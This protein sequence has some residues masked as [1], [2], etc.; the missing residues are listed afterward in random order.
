VKLRTTLQGLTAI[1]AFVAWAAWYGHQK[2]CGAF[3]E[4]QTSAYVL[5]YSVGSTYSVSQANCSRGGHHGSYKYAYD[6]VMPIGTTVTAARA[7]VVAEIRMKFRDGQPGE[8]ESNWVKIRHADG[9]IAAYSHLTEH[10][11]LVKIGDQVI[12]GQPIGLSGNTGNTG[13]LPHLHFHLCPCSEPVQCGT[14]P[15]TFRN[16]DANPEGLQPGRSYRAL[17]FENTV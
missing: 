6:F 8:A 1:A 13:G 10:G 17:P 11:A 5:P 9:T 15:V 4:W 2:S 3:P 14:L 7:G 16:T 12:A